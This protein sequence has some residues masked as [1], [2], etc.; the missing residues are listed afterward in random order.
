M[1]E[2]TAERGY[3]TVPRMARL[4][5]W[6]CAA[7]AV[8]L[9][10]LDTGPVWRHP[11]DT[12][13]FN[14]AVLW[15]YLPIPVLVAGCLAWSKRLRLRAFFLDLLELTLLKY[16]VTFTGALIMWEVTP[17]PAALPPPRRAAPEAP[18]VA[19]APSPPPTVIDPARTGT[20]AG[21]VTGADGRPLAGAPV[22]VAGGLER[23]T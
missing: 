21:V 23:L 13:T 15:S 19:D 22:Y 7:V 10:F 1:G 14:D 20:V 9:F 12:S 11:W 6:S 17:M 8:G 5:F 4:Q 18:A 3:E 2:R 16:A